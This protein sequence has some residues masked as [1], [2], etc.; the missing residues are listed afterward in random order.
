MSISLLLCPAMYRTYN[1]GTGSD[2]APCRK[3]ALG[4]IALAGV[5]LFGVCA[6]AVVAG[7]AIHQ[8]AVSST[9]A[10]VVPRM[11]AFDVLNSFLSP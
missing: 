6:G 2:Q 9:S 3:T 8:L 4:P 7:T 10:Q 11:Q 1:A 5:A